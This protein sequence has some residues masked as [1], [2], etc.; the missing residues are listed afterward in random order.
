MDANINLAL[1]D[2]I[3]TN[4]P[5]NLQVRAE[6]FCRSVDVFCES[7][8]QLPSKLGRISERTG[9]FAQLK[10]RARSAVDSGEL[11]QLQTEL[12]AV[13]ADL[14]D[15][16]ER[17]CEMTRLQCRDIVPD[18]VKSVDVVI[19][20]GNHLLP[21][22]AGSVHWNTKRFRVAMSSVGIGWTSGARRADTVRLVTDLSPDELITYQRT[23]KIF[24]CVKTYQQGIFKKKT[25]PVL[26]LLLDAARGAGLFSDAYKAVVR[27]AYGVKYNDAVFEKMCSEV[28][29]ENYGKVSDWESGMQA[30][31]Q[32]SIFEY[33][34][35]HPLAE[36]IPEDEIRNIFVLAAQKEIAGKNQGLEK[37][38]TFTK[39]KQRWGLPVP[40]PSGS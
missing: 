39:A 12:A 34:D 16:D 22:V 29:V 5:D 40:P 2:P 26:E 20:A 32:A 10:S 11:D 24:E 8:S 27:E 36:D 18:E 14:H 13:T 6:Q 15:H 30:C 25:P 9:R 7:Q 37:E 35:E 3:R 17:I 28:L 19:R 4:R 38:L 1:P 23:K 21:A 33:I 31:I